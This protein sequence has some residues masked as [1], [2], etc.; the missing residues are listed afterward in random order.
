MLYRFAA[1]HTG[2]GITLV[3]ALLLVVLAIAGPTWSALVRHGGRGR[4]VPDDLTVR[5]RRKASQDRSV[6]V[7]VTSARTRDGGRALFAGRWGIHR[8]RGSPSIWD[9]WSRRRTA[10]R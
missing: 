7:L 6:T 2:Q 10:R 5:R 1:S 4:P 8:R 9:T 3:G